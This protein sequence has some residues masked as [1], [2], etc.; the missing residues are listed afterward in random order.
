VEQ[1]AIEA[2]QSRE[3]SV[4]QPRRALH[5]GVE[6]RLDIRPRSADDAQDLGCRRLLL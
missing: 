4:T 5:N 2:E 6:N 1:L 3:H